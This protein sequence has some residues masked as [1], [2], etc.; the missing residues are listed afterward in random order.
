MAKITQIETLELNDFYFD[1]NGQPQYNIRYEYL[2]KRANDGFPLAQFKTMT[3]AE[4]YASEIEEGT[5][6][7][8]KRT[9][10]QIFSQQ[11]RIIKPYLKHECLQEEKI[12]TKKQLAKLVELVACSYI[13]NKDMHTGTPQ[14]QRLLK[15][16]YRILT[17][18]ENPE[19]ER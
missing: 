1:E 18:R 14:E 17:G 19:N 5:R 12:F 10:D 11:Q 13:Y 8:E 3:E 16:I 9:I 15:N 2:V 6:P 4:Q 7:Y